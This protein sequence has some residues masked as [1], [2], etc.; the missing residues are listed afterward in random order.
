MHNCLPLLLAQ[1]T[2]AAAETVKL[3]PH[4][5]PAELAN[6]HNNLAIGAILFGVGLV[7]FMARRNMIVMFVCAEM[8]LQGVALSL[9]AWG[10]WHND[11][12]GQIFT[13]FILT[14]AACEAAL[15]LALVMLLYR[16]SG[17][18]DIAVWQNLREAGQPAYVDRELPEDV[19]TDEHRWPRL[20]PS[21]VAPRRSDDD[22]FYA[23]QMRTP[24]EHHTW[25]PIPPED[26]KTGAIEHEG[27]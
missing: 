19:D 23:R 13:I 7:G 26:V 6:L 2:E 10:R 15:A 24:L 11:W 22:L 5:G 16:R 21:G 8:M 9:V 18:L 1:A 27:N 4:F 25:E 20:T 3:I 17:R 14:V 12:G